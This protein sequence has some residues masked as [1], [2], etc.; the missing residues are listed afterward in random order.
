MRIQITAATHRGLVRSDNQDAIV[1]DGWVSQASGAL[2][3]RTADTDSGPVVV[4]VLDG[5]GGHAG[6]AIASVL[7]AHAIADGAAG[8]AIPPTE[9]DLRDLLRGADRRVA[10]AAYGAIAEMGA[11]VAVVVATSQSLDVVSVGDCRVY[12]LDPPYLGLLTVDDRVPAPGDPGRMLVSQSLGAYRDV[13]PHVLRLDPREP[14]VLLVCSD[15]LHDALDH[16]SIGEQLDVDGNDSRLALQALVRAVLRAGAPDNV[17]V[18]LVETGFVGEVDEDSDGH[19][20]DVGI[21]VELEGVT[22]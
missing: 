11:T 12:R 16:T 9:D 1:V 15:G 19:K 21:P 22:T 6:G 10:D 14:Q 13:H 7:G 3:S 18:M 17:S 20:S 5:M 2:V 8:L 4:G